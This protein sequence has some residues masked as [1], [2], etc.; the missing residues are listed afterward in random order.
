MKTFEEVAINEFQCDAESVAYVQ[1]SEQVGTVYA[2]GGRDIRQSWR[3]C[4]DDGKSYVADIMYRYV[5]DLFV[6][7]E[8]VEE[9][10]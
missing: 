3:C 5:E 9:A 8:V 6:V 4:H 10:A 2:D 7:F 1:G